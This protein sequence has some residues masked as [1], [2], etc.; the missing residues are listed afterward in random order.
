MLRPALAGHVEDRFQQCPLFVGQATC[1]RHA[2]HRDDHARTAVPAKRD[3]P[4]Q[5]AW[6]TELMLKS[7]TRSAGV[8]VRENASS[9]HSREKLGTVS[10]AWV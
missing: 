4:S 10:E 3:T 2:V 6:E 8:A 1:V 5:S 7:G 9:P